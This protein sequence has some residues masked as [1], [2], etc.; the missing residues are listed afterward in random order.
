VRIVWAPQAH[1]DRRDIWDFI[2]IDSAAAAA[3][4]DD[5]FAASVTRLADFPLM[6]K[7]GKISD[8]RELIPHENYRIVYE[9][10]SNAVRVL[11]LVHVSR[12]WPPVD[13]ERFSAYHMT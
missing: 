9:V 13:V 1:Q 4:M 2:A 5:L 6:G 7:P 11:A 8:T 12:R 3:R 10:D